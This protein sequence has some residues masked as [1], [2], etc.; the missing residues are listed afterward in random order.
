MGKQPISNNVQGLD[1]SDN[2]KSVNWNSDSLNHPLFD[3]LIEIGDK[4]QDVIAN[5]ATKVNDQIENL[6]KQVENIEESGE[7]IKRIKENF[8]IINK[9]QLTI[10]KELDDRV[11]QIN[12]SR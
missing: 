2:S 6:K 4:F 11:E 12:K 5:L 9:E 7:K 3:N 1:S 10:K 8:V